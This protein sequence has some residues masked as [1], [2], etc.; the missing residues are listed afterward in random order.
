MPAQTDPSQIFEEYVSLV[1]DTA[2]QKSVATPGQ[3]PENPE[4]S[5]LSSKPAVELSQIVDPEFKDQTQSPS[6]EKVE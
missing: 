3:I 6:A 5:L 2:S 4:C 1:S